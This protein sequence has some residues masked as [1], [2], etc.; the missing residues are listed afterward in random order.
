MKSIFSNVQTYK[1]TN[2]FLLFLLSCNF[3]FAQATGTPA[4]LG[5]VVKAHSLALE[6][7][8]DVDVTVTSAAKSTNTV[9]QNH[10][11]LPSVFTSPNATQFANFD[12]VFF[13]LFPD[14][15]LSSPPPVTS[16][17]VVLKRDFDILNG[18]SVSDLGAIQ[19][20]V[21]GTIPFSEYWQYV[22]ADASLNGRVSMQ[23][24]VIIRKVI[25]KLYPDYK[26]QGFSSESW[27][28]ADLRNFLT[29]NSTGGGYTLTSAGKQYFDNP[30]TIPGYP[31]TVLG[32]SDHP[33]PEGVLLN[34]SQQ[35]RLYD[36][37]KTGHCNSVS[38]PLTLQA[39]NNSFS[40]AVGSQQ[41]QQ[42]FDIEQNT[43]IKKGDIFSVTFSVK[44]SAETL[45]GFQ[46]ATKINQKSVS[47]IDVKSEDIPNYKNENLNIDT[48]NNE[49][50]SLW[51]SNDGNIEKINEDKHLFT[52]SLRANEN[53]EDVSQVFPIDESILPTEF[54]NINNIPTSGNIKL[55]VDK[56]SFISETKVYPTNFTDRLTI[57][58][59]TLVKSEFVDF[60]L[61]RVDGTLAFSKTINVE[62]GN[63]NNIVEGLE[64]LTKGAYYYVLKSNNG[65]IKNSGLLTK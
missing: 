21:L 40:N 37:F 45:Y 48:K 62:E 65:T 43:P 13:H 41:R 33:F 6:G 16:Y 32:N 1:R 2:V 18:V 64:S 14:V 20:H 53:I 19:S 29:V 27:S 35:I 51:L 3:L 58:L 11:A 28:F 25:L 10:P 15:V 61:Y 63:N 44:P 38:T 42:I 56:Q 34:S 57:D 49:L 17:S 26:S 55:K 46:F 59:S 12:G 22:G 60:Y 9:T 5:V 23:D 4:L 7:V 31:W 39:N 8:N 50:R 47:L 36:A 54:V 52:I 30:T 24:V